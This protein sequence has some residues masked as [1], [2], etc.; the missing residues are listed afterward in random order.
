MAQVKPARWLERIRRSLELQ[1]P[2]REDAARFWRGYTGDYSDKGRKSL[3]DVK[4]DIF[5]NFIYSYIENTL[6]QIFSGDPRVSIEA[7]NQASE[8]SSK[9]ME[10]VINYWFK[11][12][13]SKEHIK[14]AVFDR[15]LGYGAICTE[16][17]YDEVLSRV[18]SIMGINPDG[19]F[20]HGVPIDQP[21][22]LKDQPSLRW[23]NPFN[24]IRDPDS[25]FKMFDRYRVERLII[26]EEQF[27]SIDGVDE[28]AC[29]LIKPR[30]IPSDLARL[31]LD[32]DLRRGSDKEWVILYKIY[33]VENDE[34]L[35]LNE[36]EDV[37]EYLYVKPW[38]YEFEVGGDRFP[39]T[40]LDGKPSPDSNYGMSEFRAYWTQINERNAVRK[41][42]QAVNRRSRPSYISKKKS[43]SEEEL[44][45]FANVK[46]GEVI[47]MS[48]PE[49]V[50]ARPFAEVPIDLYKYD[51]ISKD[52][53]EQTSSAI[54]SRN[55]SIADT[56]TE[57]SLI[58]SKGN[59]RTG[60]SREELEDF[61]AIIGAKIGGL[62][63]QFM[64]KSTAVK[65]K[66]PVNPR[67]LIWLDANKDQIQGEFAYSIKPGVMQQHNEG[68][69]R[70]QVLKYAEIMGQNPNV[71]QRFVAEKV[72]ESFE[73]DP[74]DA[75]KS[76]QEMQQEAAQQ[77]PEDPPIQFADIKPE[78]LDPAVQNMV[79]MA[80][81]QQNG[82]DI[83]QLQQQMSGTNG[84]QMADN[85]QGMPMP[86]PDMSGEMSGLNQA[87]A[88]MEGA[89]MPPPN[90]ISPQSEMQGGA[91]GGS[92]A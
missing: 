21:S 54:E 73:F 11:E 36:G 59:I 53:L 86:P 19:S 56:A 8:A 75:L 81:L 82:V 34:I 69:R 67:E 41:T 47:E 46:I 44:S 37:Q 52:D 92:L 63:Q 7:K 31:P 90:P 10:A 50:I 91:T 4:D 79:V 61:V 65:I 16:W 27:D 28:T 29:K 57:A 60:A 45:A 38:P 2:R 64:D 70:Q 22:V 13:G 23:I 83:S 3:D 80:A 12:L 39:I 5:L 58:A 6:P 68:L 26:T 74:T 77:K 17:D 72:T 88:P 62:C 33:D 32:Q 71:N 51:E 25:P 14:R 15:F 24:V 76:E 1:K 48:N 85:Q 42:L 87:P 9:H 55:N 35:L 40:I 78:L 18:P 89:M 49:G 43:N 66:N 84:G 30:A 20:I